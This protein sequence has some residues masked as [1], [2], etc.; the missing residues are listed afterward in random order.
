MG[1]FV[2]LFSDRLLAVVGFAVDFAVCIL[3]MVGFAVGESDGL[4]VSAMVGLPVGALD[5]LAVRPCIRLGSMGMI[6]A[7]FAS[8]LAKDGLAV[9]AGEGV[10]DG[11]A[12]VGTLVGANDALEVVGVNGLGTKLSLVLKCRILWMLGVVVS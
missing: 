10:T 3:A 5:G 6:S 4:S 8:P 2:D 11:L 7:G 1:F 9:G 12:V